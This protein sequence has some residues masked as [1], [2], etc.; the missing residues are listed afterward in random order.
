[1]GKAANPWG[2]RRPIREGEGGQSVGA[3]A[4]SEAPSVN[5]TDEV[6][7]LDL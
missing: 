5:S 1:V 6:E 2:R 7:L 3:K 4:A